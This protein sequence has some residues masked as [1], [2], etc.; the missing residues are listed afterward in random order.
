[1][2]EYETR[3][4]RSR[5]VIVTAALLA[6]LMALGGGVG[7]GWTLARL[8]VTPQTAS[9]GSSNTLPPAFASGGASAPNAA[10]D[11]VEPAIVDINTEVETAQG[12]TPAAGTGMI[13]TSG[14]EILTNNHDIA[15]ATSIR[16]VVQGRSGDY[17]ARVLGVDPTADVALLQISGASG[18]QTVK[19]A[20]A[21]SIKVG[22]SVI[23]IGN[24]LGQ[25]GTPS[26][27]EGTITALNQQITAATEGGSSEQLSGMIESDA[28]ISPGDSGG[29]LVDSSG[30][31]VGMITAGQSRGFRSSTSTTGY[32]VPA[33]TAQG[34]VKQIRSGHATAQVLIGQPGYIGVQVQDLDAATAAQLGLATS[35]GV[36]V[37]G[38]Q[39]GSPAE[40]AGLSQN[41][42]ITA[43]NGIATPSVDALGAQ[44][45]Q[46]HPGESITVTWTDQQ[47]SSH[48][49]R[50][51]LISGPAV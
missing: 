20:P 28:P 16:V 6:V 19:F 51:T 1:M 36:L 43:V 25:G 12:T 23:A 24:A 37:T 46:H 44:I 29:A 33:A 21:S 18:L 17:A 31:V 2:Y 27:T 34:I 26:V 35:S 41:S 4:G 15:G 22:E 40:Q 32:A 14:G 38:V 47:G 8:I 48:S 3:R 10:L 49:A 9:R 7:I 45:H 11:R 30:Q 13:L 5:A 50:M 42:V 39:S